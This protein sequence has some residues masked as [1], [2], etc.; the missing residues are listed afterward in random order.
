M[1][2][3]PKTQSISKALLCK[4]KPCSDKGRA[5]NQLEEPIST[6]KLT[7]LCKDDER[8]GSKDYSDLNELLGEGWHFRGINSVGDNCY[9]VPNTVK[10]YLCRRRPIIHYIPKNDG[11]PVRIRTPQGFMLYFTFI[12]G[13]GTSADF[14][15]NKTVFYLN[16][17]S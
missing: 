5:V 3:I 7:D 15:I 8:D 4:T 12:Q 11:T 1:P 6:D 2:A 17:N 16:N 14:G 9:V 10:Y 13:A